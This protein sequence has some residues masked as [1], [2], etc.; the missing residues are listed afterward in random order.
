[1]FAYSDDADAN[2]GGLIQPTVEPL[3]FRF[4]TPL[5]EARGVKV[6]GVTVD[7]SNYTLT[8][9]STIITFTGEYSASLAEGAHEIGLIVDS[10]LATKNFT[11]E[12]TSVPEEG[13]IRTFTAYVHDGSC[14]LTGEKVEFTYEYGM[15]WGEFCASEYN[16]DGIFRNVTQEWMDELE[17]SGFD[18]GSI[19]LDYSGTPDFGY[20]TSDGTDAFRRIGICSEDLID[21]ALLYVIA[22]DYI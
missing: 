7:E 17:I 2:T 21:E 15:T 22:Y 19:I 18:V 6:D 11:V 12:P 13:E 3:V 16:S 4:E 5:S 8:E 14:I 9:G 1:M 10:G 20:K